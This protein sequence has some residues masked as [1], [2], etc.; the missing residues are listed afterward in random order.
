M[1]ASGPAVTHKLSW[2][3]EPASEPLQPLPHQRPF[4][5]PTPFIVSNSLCSESISAPR[6]HQPRS[7]TSPTR[8]TPCFKDFLSSDRPQARVS[9]A[10]RDSPYVR[11]SFQCIPILFQL[12]N[13]AV[14]ITSIIFRATCLHDLQTTRQPSSATLTRKYV[15][16]FIAIRVPKAKGSVDSMA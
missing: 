14:I 11:A 13:H 9:S 15:R 6:L 5:D 10:L 1:S 12:Q 2:R 4:R 8:P 3:K 16:L 7:S